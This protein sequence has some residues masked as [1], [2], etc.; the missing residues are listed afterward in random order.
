MIKTIT[1]T[2]FKREPL[3]TKSEQQQI[4]QYT[5]QIKDEKQHFRQIG[6]RIVFNIAEQTS[7]FQAEYVRELPLVDALLRHSVGATF[8]ID[9]TEFNQKHC[10]DSRAP[11]KLGTE[12]PSEHALLFPVKEKQQHLHIEVHGFI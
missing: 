8:T 3:P 1:I 10:Y 9:F 6:A 2:Q 11:Y 5:W 4:W 7:S 12:L